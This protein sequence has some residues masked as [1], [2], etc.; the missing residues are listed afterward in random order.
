MS[1]RE[2]NQTQ[3]IHLHRLHVG[4]EIAEYDS[5]CAWCSIALHSLSI[6]RVC[7]A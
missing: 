5:A 3:Y 4:T 7:V 6:V 2:R 1:N